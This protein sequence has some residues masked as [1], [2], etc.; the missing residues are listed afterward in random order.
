MK[1][2]RKDNE[3]VYLAC[4]ANRL[5][6]VCVDKKYRDD[7]ELAKIC[8]QQIKNHNSI[9]YS[10][11]KRLKDNKELA[12]LDLQE[13]HPHSE[14][15]SARLKNDD[16]IAEKLFELHGTKSFAWYHMSKRLRKKYR[17]TDD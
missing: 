5:N 12:M 4:K 3:L 11:S 9:F 14:Y 16:E 13:D 10:L 15:Y 2:Y 17:I 1:P 6:F 7:F 8:M